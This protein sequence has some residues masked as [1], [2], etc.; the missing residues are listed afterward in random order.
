MKRR[1]KKLKILTYNIKRERL[2]T[3]SEQLVLVALLMS[4]MDFRLYSLH[5]MVIAFVM[6]CIAK[7]RLRLTNGAVPPLLLTVT[8]LFFWRGDLFS[9]TV[10][11]KRF[12]WPAA[13]LLGYN[14]IQPDEGS[15]EMGKAEKKAQALFMLAAA[16]F[17]IHLLLNLFM[18]FNQNLDNRNT[19]D[20]WTG[21]NRSATGQAGLMCV[22]LAWCVAC[23]S[24][25]KGL[26][27]ILPASIALVAMLYYNLILGSR[28]IVIAF[29]IVTFVA[30]FYA[31]GNRINGQKA[32]RIL[33]SVAGWSLAVAVL[34]INDIG[35]V[36][37]L[38]E[39][40]ILGGRMLDTSLLVI[41][42]DDRWSAKLRYLELMP[43]YML[44]GNNIRRIVGIYAHDILLD[45]Y[46]EASVFAFLAIIAILWDAVF[47]MRRFMKC[48]QFSTGT[49]ATVLCVYVMMFLEFA[50]EPIFAGMPWLLMTFCFFHGIIT[51]LVR[52]ASRVS[53]L[54]IKEQRE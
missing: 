46:D 47:K 22:P 37:T 36:R 51:C 24:T 26:K 27:T 50:V 39:E 8:L 16:G 23:I 13:F 1:K 10:W 41:I 20:F 45:T 6:W 29:I 52:N 5:I 42:E 28:T 49:K 19:I 25:R 11:M 15:D 30:L 3:T 35:G 21:E 34:Y 43:Q 31:L 14:L 4:F 38:V 17:L 7:G 53:N 44:G 9:P 32:Q 33:V 40:S 54:H 18:T 12:V 2:F 48:G